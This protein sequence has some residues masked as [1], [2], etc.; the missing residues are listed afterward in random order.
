MSEKATPGALDNDYAKQFKQAC[1]EW[2]DHRFVSSDQV[3]NLAMF[4]IY[5]VNLA[6]HAGWL[7]CGHSYKAGVGMS[8]LVVKAM[9]D[10][11]PMVCFTS[12]RT[13]CNCVGIFVRK[14]LNDM[15]EW[16]PDQYR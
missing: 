16:R 9:V 15:V 6:D 8:V 10:D 14:M 2:T 5:I 3:Y 7:Y 13:F 11:M 1:A 4:S 12:G